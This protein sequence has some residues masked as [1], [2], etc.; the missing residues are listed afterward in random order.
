MHHFI[1]TLCIYLFWCTF[2][3][4]RKALRNFVYYA[5]NK[6]YLLLLLL[7]DLESLYIK[8]T[9]ANSNVYLNVEHFYDMP[10]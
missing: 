2:N 10:F 3:F 6:C 7:F 9:I 4:V 5:L 1:V 8:C